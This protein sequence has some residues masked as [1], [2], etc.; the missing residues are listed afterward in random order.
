MDYFKNLK[1]LL[2][3]IEVKDVK[4]ENLEVD[5]AV[6]KI[7]EM[8]S[9]AQKKDRKVMFI[10]N[11]GSAS[12][13]SHMTTDLLK[14]G[15]IRAVSFNDPTLL[16]CI[17]NDL[18]YENVFA[19]PIE[20]LASKGDILFAISSSGQ[21]KN[22]LNAVKAA[23]KRGCPV[24]TLSGFSATNPLRRSGGINFYVPSDVYGYV[25]I[26]HSAICHY[27]VDRICGVK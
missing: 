24:V 15:G 9:A 17:S 23:K 13:A 14:N 5:K 6:S 8:I 3:R 18:G 11:G 12:I 20:I 19:R 1:E 22:I 25:E 27:I 21:S 7:V 2:S 4:D 16:T 26:V 10:G